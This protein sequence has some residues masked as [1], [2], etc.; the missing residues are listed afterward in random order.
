MAS[1][2]LKNRP[3]IKKKS[4]LPGFLAVFSI[5]TA[6]VA[7][8]F[9]G[10]SAVG[11][12]WFDDLPDYRDTSYF[13]TAQKTTVYANDGTT[14]LAEFYIENREPVTLEEMSPYVLDGII[15]IEDERFYEHDGV[16]LWAVARAAVVNLTGGAREGASTITQQFVRQTILADEANDITLERKAREM[17]IAWELEKEYSKDEILNMYLNAINFGS[18]AY[19]IEAAAQRYFSK[20]ALELNLVEAATLV[21]IPQSPTF[22]NPHR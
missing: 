14:I 22:N 20:P 17:Y 10:V 4:M 19:G 15:A 6:L 2:A 13:E 9:V 8:L 1:R 7:S 3:S 5:C 12:T 18:G 16:D 21:G 11:S